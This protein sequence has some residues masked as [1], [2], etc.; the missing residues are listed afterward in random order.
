MGTCSG[1]CFLPRQ[2]LLLPTLSLPVESAPSPGL[3][4]SE[5][6]WP[7]TT[8]SLQVFIFPRWRRLWVSKQGYSVSSGLS[9]PPASASPA[10]PPCPS[11]ESFGWNQMPI[12]QSSC[13]LALHSI[14]TIK[15]GASLGPSDLLRA[16]GQSPA[17]CC[18]FSCCGCGRLGLRPR[19]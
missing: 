18:L 7:T 14:Q 16:A 11:L 5:L 17:K 15:P 6:P 2:S 10:A 3:S 4:N 19:E 12:G 8:V 1:P 9:H 13:C